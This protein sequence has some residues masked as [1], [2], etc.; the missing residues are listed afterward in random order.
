MLAQETY[1][2]LRSVPNLEPN[3]LKHVAV[4]MPYYNEPLF[5]LRSVC[6]VLG[7]SHHNFHLFIV[8]DGSDNDKK[9]RDLIPE[10]PKITILE[11]E[12]GG[13]SSARNLA[14]EQIQSWFMPFDYIAY[15]DSDDIWNSN[16]LTESIDVLE[17][18]GFDMIYSDVD[19]RFP[20]NSRAVSFGIPHYNDFP[21]LTSLLKQNFIYISSV[22]H[23]VKCLDIGNFDSSLD[24]LEDWDFWIRIAKAGYNIGKNYNSII[25]YT[26]KP[27]GSGSKRTDEIYKNLLKKHGIS[28]SNNSNS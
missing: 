13:V 28:L 8:D 25:R 9:A 27:D 2:P 5:L 10:M 23:C 22:V 14:L 26:C 1:P 15:C 16:H 21:G 6:G 3:Y 11:K 7:Q 18:D 17:N 19:L 12:N 20:D 4:V 24:S